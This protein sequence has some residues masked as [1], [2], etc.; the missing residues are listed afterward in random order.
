MKSKEEPTLGSSVFDR[1]FI[2]SS[3]GDLFSLGKLWSNWKVLCPI[4][5]S[6]WTSG[7][8]RCGLWNTPLWTAVFVIVLWVDST[9]SG[10]SRVIGKSFHSISQSNWTSGLLRC[11]SWNN[12]LWA[13][14]LSTDN[15]GNLH[16]RSFSFSRRGVIG[17][18][19]I[20]RYFHQFNW[21]SGLLR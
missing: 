11:G 14:V 21:L 2:D 12:Q 4:Y 3:L 15:S 1:Q 20:Q 13:A 9:L 19:S 17:K 5:Q 6:N 7:L 16:W 10:N 8:L 18:L